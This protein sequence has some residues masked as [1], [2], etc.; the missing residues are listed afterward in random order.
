MRL[1]Q[2]LFSAYVICTGALFLL[3]Q[4]LN[5]GNIFREEIPANPPYN[6][7]STGKF[8]DKLS[9]TSQTYDVKLPPAANFYDFDGNGSMG[10]ANVI[11]IQNWDDQSGN[12]EYL[13]LYNGI[14]EKFC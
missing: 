10:F 5:A 13:H 11:R 1:N 14:S 8:A 3:T 4:Q 6:L 9:G 12:G 2:L 7:V